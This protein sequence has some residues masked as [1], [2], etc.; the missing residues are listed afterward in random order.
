MEKKTYVFHFLP[1]CSKSASPVPWADPQLG[2]V[3]GGLWDIWIWDHHA[4]GGS[5]RR[6]VLKPWREWMK[7]VLYLEDSWTAPE[8]ASWKHVL[9]CSADEFWISWKRVVF[10]IWCNWYERIGMTCCT[11]WWQAAHLNY[12][13]SGVPDDLKW[14]QFQTVSNLQMWYD[15]P[16]WQEVDK[17][18]FFG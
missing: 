8:S 9:I 10:G 15:E 6:Q 7:T 13:T 18:C 11:V 2:D 17:P 5:G 16:S 14:F 1:L 12:G 3:S 4:K